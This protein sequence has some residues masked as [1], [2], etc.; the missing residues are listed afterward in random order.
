[1]RLIKL[2][3]AFVA[4][5][6]TSVVSANPALNS[7]VSGPIAVPAAATTQMVASQ[8]QVRIDGTGLTGHLTGNLGGTDVRSI[9]ASSR[10]R[11]GRDQPGRGP[12]PLPGPARRARLPGPP[13]GPAYRARLTAAPRDHSF[14]LSSQLTSWPRCF[15]AESS[16][17]LS[18]PFM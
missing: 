15:S 12:A 3:W 9:S 11:L 16:P 13:T 8:S 18:T 4:L 17:A 2:A 5:S 14:T 10:L 1:M 6:V 7:N